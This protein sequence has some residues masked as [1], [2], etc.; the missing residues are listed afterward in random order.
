MM[1]KKDKDIPESVPFP[2]E[3]MMKKYAIHMPNGETRQYFTNSISWM[4]ALAIEEGYTEIHYYGV[5]MC[6]VSE[7]AY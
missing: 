2:K 6:S 4:T 5:H 1:Q 3:E 7:Y